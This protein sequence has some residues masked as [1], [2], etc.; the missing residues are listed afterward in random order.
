MRTLYVVMSQ[1][2]AREVIHAAIRKGWA[3]A[4][5]DGSG[6]GSIDCLSGGPKL[7]RVLSDPGKQRPDD[8]RNDLVFA[9][10]RLADELRP[11]TFVIEN[12]RGLLF[13]KVRPT[14]DRLL[15]HLSSAG[16]VLSPRT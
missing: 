14:L 3:T 2:W 10:A 13:E 1:P 8:H 7:P 6:T 12:V 15:K 11:R 4:G 9:F 16:Y 5:R